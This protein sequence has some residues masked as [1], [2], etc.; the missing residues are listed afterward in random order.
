M[1]RGKGVYIIIKR[2]TCYFA[3][4]IK[5]KYTGS[6]ISRIKWWLSQGIGRQDIN[7]INWFEDKSR[8]N[9]LDIKSHKSI[10]QHY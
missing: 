6:I 1:S 2:I 8:N 7:H 3:Y 4:F 10:T 5:Y 9:K